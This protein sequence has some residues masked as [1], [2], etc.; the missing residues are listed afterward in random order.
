MTVSSETSDHRA[1]RGARPAAAHDASRA[2]GW[3]LC[4]EMARGR[5][6]GLHGPAAYW[7]EAGKTPGGPRSLQA[8]LLA[9][10]QAGAQKT[11]PRAV[12]FTFVTCPD[13]PQER[14]DQERRATCKDAQDTTEE[15]GQEDRGPGEEIQERP[16]PSG[17]FE[18][19]P[20]E[21]ALLVVHLLQ[22]VLQESGRAR[23]VRCS[24]ADEDSAHP[25]SHK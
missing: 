12:F 24:T 3:P 4:R 25:R 1:D 9:G 17:G 6:C 20:W 22:G 10:S 13:K 11:P 21:L 8:S 5:D 18:L 7:T 23:R 14:Q 16:R 19:L 15:R 2:G